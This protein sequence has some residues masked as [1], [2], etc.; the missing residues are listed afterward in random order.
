MVEIL[1]RGTNGVYTKNLYSNVI[2]SA[3]FLFIDIA[4]FAIN[5]AATLS[6]LQKE[7]PILQSANWSIIFP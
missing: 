6:D 7:K 5:Q 3:A 1:N 2:N 4:F